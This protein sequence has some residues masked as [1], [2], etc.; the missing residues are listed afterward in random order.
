M[1]GTTR[2]SSLAQ[3]VL[4]LTDSL[5][6]EFDTTDQETAELVDLVS[7]CPA[8]QT[9]RRSDG[10]SLVTGSRGHDRTPGGVGPFVSAKRRT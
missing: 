6:P 1:L 9:G 5:G 8:Q 4:E 7:D 2:T 3:V 10:P